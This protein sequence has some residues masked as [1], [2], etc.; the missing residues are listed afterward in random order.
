MDR[1]SQKDR[2]LNRVANIIYDAFKVLN[3]KEN[4][5]VLRKTH[6]DYANDFTAEHLELIQD[7]KLKLANVYNALVEDDYKINVD[8]L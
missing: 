4:L 1:R 7:A 8:S 3:D 2:D 5:L 6:C